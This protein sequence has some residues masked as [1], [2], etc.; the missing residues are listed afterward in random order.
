MAEDLNSE[1]LL[2]SSEGFRLLTGKDKAGDV[3]YAREYELS[4]GVDRERL[5]TRVEPLS[6]SIIPGLARVKSTE[7]SDSRLRIVQSEIKGANLKTLLKWEPGS[8][9]PERFR[10]WAFEYC[11]FLRALFNETDWTPSAIHLDQIMITPEDHLVVLAPG[12]EGLFQSSKVKDREAEFLN[13]FREFTTPLLEHLVEQGHEVSSLYWIFQHRCACLDDLRESL[14][15]GSPFIS[16]SLD[17]V[18]PLD[19]FEVP[20]VP[21]ARGLLELFL[22]QSP[23]ILVLEFALLAA[24]IV[25]IHQ[26]TR[27]RPLPVNGVYVLCESEVRLLD[28]ASGQSLG[29]LKLPFPARAIALLENP[30]R[31]A[32]AF[33]NQRRVDI[34]DRSTGKKTHTF[35]AEGPVTKMVVAG[36][37]LYL[38][39]GSYPGVL[40]YDCEK[41]EAT[42]VLLTAP[43]VTSMAITD[44]AL[45][46]ACREQGKLYSFKIPEGKLL[47]QRESIGVEVVGADNESD[48]FVTFS[49]GA[50][51]GTMDPETL[52][53]SYSVSKNP[54]WIITQI[55]TEPEGDV[56]WAFSPTNG[57]TLLDRQSLEPIAHQL[58]IPGKPGEAILVQRGQD[59]DFW[60][61]LPQKKT[62]SILDGRDRSLK[63]KLQV[64]NTPSGLA[65]SSKPSEE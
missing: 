49:A 13:Q 11:L 57:C 9:T 62:V 8:I 12:W 26:W 30:P 25:G 42:R 34:L 51:F 3:Y 1:E 36:N 45:I 21:V 20:D 17:D 23:L 29:K 60:V 46:V 40:V 32:V 22:S 35:L 63:K 59:A 55:I 31:I 48:C 37:L 52:N 5:S 28:S 7:L 2:H 39:Q 54:D 27:P 58:Q 10:R 6:S 4:E 44:K 16:S 53:M 43:E 24:L 33:R 38:N 64:P 47:N 18:K 56:C 14:D 61:S 15:W 41:E 65:S 19:S 50:R